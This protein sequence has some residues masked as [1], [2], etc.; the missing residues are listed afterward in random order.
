M[1]TPAGGWWMSVCSDCA[2]EIAERKSVAITKRTFFSKANHL[3]RTSAPRKHKASVTE[4]RQRPAIF[5]GRRGKH[6]GAQSYQMRATR[7]SQPF[8]WR[9]WRVTSPDHLPGDGS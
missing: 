5:G 4:L 2:N 8:A 7:Q 6:N 9:L 3:S 1:P